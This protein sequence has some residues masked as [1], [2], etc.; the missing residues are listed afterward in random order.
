MGHN[1]KT[2]PSVKKKLKTRR[3][4]GK[5]KAKSQCLSILG[6]NANGISGKKHSL[7]AAIQTFN[8]NIITIQE[9][10]L[11]EK[12]SFT[13]PGYQSFV[14][15]RQNMGRGG[16]LTLVESDFP[17]IEVSD[18]ESDILVVEIELNDYKL[19]VINF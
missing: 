17:A 2:V 9:S 13:I 10:K 14:K 5:G 19:R 3:G 18:L 15:N 11:T 7:Q 8:P 4:R 12:Q 6:N 16:L 1:G